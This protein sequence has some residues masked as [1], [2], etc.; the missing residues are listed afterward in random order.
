[1]TTDRIFKIL[2]IDCQVVVEIEKTQKEM[3]SWLDEYI[4]NLPYDW[5]DASDETFEILYKDGT[6]D[7]IDQEYDGH[8]IRR[9][10]IKSFCYNNACS[11]IV[12]GAFEINEY[13]VVYASDVEKIASENIVEV[14]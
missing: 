3:F 2:D 6:V 1:M 8:K 13:G 11:A 5:F 7:I 4:D 12:Y 10:N 14:R 9:N